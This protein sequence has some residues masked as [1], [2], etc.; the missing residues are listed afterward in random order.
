MC[1]R[2]K[3]AI[4]LAMVM[5]GSSQELTMDCSELI[6]TSIRVCER[7]QEAD[8]VGSVEMR[9]KVLVLEYL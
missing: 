5:V 4:Q 8:E 6:V 1:D 7:G 9:C 2:G 3:L